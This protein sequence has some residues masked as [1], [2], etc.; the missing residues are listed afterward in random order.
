[1]VLAVQVRNQVPV[2][3]QHSLEASLWTHTFDVKALSAILLNRLRL[4]VPLG[5]WL[6]D[7][8]S[9]TAFMRLASGLARLLDQAV[10]LHKT[11]MDIFFKKRGSRDES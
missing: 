2:D 10:Q 3:Y 6:R 11:I 4:V 5:R 7:L 1:M 9:L 8:L